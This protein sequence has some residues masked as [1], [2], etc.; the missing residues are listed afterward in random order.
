MRK[1]DIEPLGNIDA[2][3]FGFSCNDFSVAGERDL[4]E[5]L[6]RYTHMA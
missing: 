1:L 6:D 4:M 3:V 2:S 5:L